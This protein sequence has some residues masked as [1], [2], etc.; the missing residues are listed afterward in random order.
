MVPAAT[1]E[2]EEE[3]EEEEEVLGPVL[4]WWPWAA[5]AS[6]FGEASA[7]SSTSEQKSTSGG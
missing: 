6:V 1:K 5:E 3:G 4:G 2:G 7:S